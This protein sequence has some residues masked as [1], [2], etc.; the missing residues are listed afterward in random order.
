[1]I[2]KQSLW[3]ALLLV[4]VFALP[5]WSLP[6]SMIMTMQISSKQGGR[7]LKAD[8]KLWYANQKFRAEI[9][10]NMNMAQGKSPVKISNKATI[11]TDLK[12]KIALC[13]SF[14]GA[15]FFKQKLTEAEEFL[16]MALSF[17]GH[18]KETL[19]NYVCLALEQ[20]D[21]E[22]ALFYAA[23]LEETDFSLLQQIRNAN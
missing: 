18:H 12:S 11:I 5:G 23:K 15:C 8:A 10:S 16:T 22:K 7:P 13:N 1:M 4:A 17:D 14:A 21:K 6:K 3:T 19:R 2:K 20:K 9:T